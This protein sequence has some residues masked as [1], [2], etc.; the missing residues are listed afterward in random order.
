MNPKLGENE[1]ASKHEDMAIKDITS[2]Q[3]TYQSF[4]KQNYTM[5]DN[6]KLAYG[7]GTKQEMRLL[8]AD[9]EKIYGV[10][11]DISSYADVVEAIH[12]MQER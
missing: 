4:A 9:A 5:R 6:L 12:I 11:Y 3:N 8:L 7:G 2:I 1:K 10:K